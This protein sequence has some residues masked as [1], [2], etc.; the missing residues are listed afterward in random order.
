[1]PSPSPV[2]PDGPR[3]GLVLNAGGARGAY[4]TGVLDVLLPVLEERGER[5]TVLV[6][7]SA[8]ALNV[9]L[10]A[11]AAHLPAAEQARVLVDGL[12][13][14]TLHAVLRPLWKQLPLVA[15][16]YGSE[17]LGAKGMRLTG[18]LGTEPLRG[19]LRRVVDWDALHRNVADGTV[20]AATLMATVVRTGRV[21]GFTET[22]GELPETRPGSDHVY[23]EVRLDVEHAMASA[24]IP[25]LFPAVRVEEPAEAA[26][27][28]V[29]GATRLR[30]PLRPAVDHGVD[31][32]IVVGTTSLQPRWSDPLRDLENVD[33]GDSAV[34]MLNAMIDDALRRDVRRLGEVN[35]FFGTPHEQALQT[36]RESRGRRPFRP[37]PFVAVTPDGAE[38]IDDLARD[39]YHRRY[40]TLRRLL[41]NPD[42]QLLHRALGSD[43]PLQGQLLSF[44]LF[45]EEY[46]DALAAMGRRDAHRWLAGHP[47][48]WQTDP[49][50]TLVP[51]SA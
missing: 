43:S 6:G 29:D 49:V 45:D 9:C 8:G 48:M 23:R 12:G 51:S 4:Q 11:S 21:V 2:S 38:E 32:V 50:E 14:A 16:R 30:S 13:E 10:L 40:G 1:M 37:L 42:L 39:V 19:T 41:T 25:V 20:A 15:L 47:D 44:L 7:T 5:P 18:L 35:S 26:G 36:Y 46:F 17:T 28:Y 34:T 33:L 3:V 24:A 22:A 27:W 31:R